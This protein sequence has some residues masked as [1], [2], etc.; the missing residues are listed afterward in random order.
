MTWTT[1]LHAMAD[2]STCPPLTRQ[3]VQEA[4]ERI[5]RYIHHTPVVTCETINELASTP[6]SQRC[7]SSGANTASE[8]SP[9]AHDQPG[10]AAKY[11]AKP[12]VKL[13]FKCENQQRIGAFKARGAFHALG[14][15][16]GE[17]GL[18]N[19]RR[20]GVVT[21]SSGMQPHD[22]HPCSLLL[23]ANSIYLIRQPC[24]STGVSSK[25]TRRTR[26]HCHADH[27]HTI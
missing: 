19:V 21:H 16:I 20:K 1:A 23:M 26:A 11:T 14:R 27:Q 12:K 22:P 15:L 9:H 6:Q 24:T 10:D 25:D 7:P 2:P 13:F 3:S 18:E 17:E 5:K 4:H 8:P